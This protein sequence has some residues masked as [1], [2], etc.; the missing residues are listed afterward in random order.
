ME[1]PNPRQEEGNNTTDP[2]ACDEVVEGT[3]PDP[4]NDEVPGGI[5]VRHALTANPNTNNNHNHNLNPSH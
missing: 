5:D 3:N 2:P 1:P 4:P